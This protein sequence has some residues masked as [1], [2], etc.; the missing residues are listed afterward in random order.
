LELSCAALTSIK[1]RNAQCGNP[2][3]AVKEVG[4]VESLPSKA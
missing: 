1:T 4:T 3:A 2:V